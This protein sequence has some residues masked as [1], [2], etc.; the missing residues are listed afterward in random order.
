MTGKES[1]KCLVCVNYYLLVEGKEN[2]EKE[3]FKFLAGFMGIGILVGW[4]EFQSSPPTQYPKMKGRGG[5][6]F[7]G[8]TSMNHHGM[9]SYNSLLLNLSTK[10]WFIMI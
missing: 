8:G 4:R 6:I 10:Y 3:D 7:L 5:N 2:L 9:L 1:N